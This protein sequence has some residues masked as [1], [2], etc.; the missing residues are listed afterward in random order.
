M[1]RDDIR[2]RFRIAPEKLHVIYNGVDVGH[3]HPRERERL[4]QRTRADLGIGADDPAF[5]YVGSGFARKGL[6]LAIDALAR[7]ANPRFRL[8][9]AGR[10]R[11]VAKFERR[12][13]SAGVAARCTFLAARTTC[14]R[15]MRPPTASCCRAS[16]I[17]SAQPCSK[18]WQWDCL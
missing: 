17:H 18:R 13:R 4:R 15:R 10:D 2:R 1:V 16:M 12:A 11:D 8:L 7:A 9:V 14:G 6:R 3:F 5:V